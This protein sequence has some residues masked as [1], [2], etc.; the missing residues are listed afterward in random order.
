MKLNYRNEKYSNR[1]NKKSIQQ[2]V[3]VEEM[4]YKQISKLESRSIQFTQFET[5][6]RKNIISAERDCRPFYRLQC[7]PSSTLA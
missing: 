2:M 4:T 5:T 7:T 3:S 6:E 1:N